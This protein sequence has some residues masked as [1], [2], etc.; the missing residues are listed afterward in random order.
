MKKPCGGA[1]VMKETNRDGRYSPKRIQNGYV[2]AFGLCYVIGFSQC[3]YAQDYLITPNSLP[4]LVKAAMA[5]S[6]C[7][8]LCPADIC[9]L[10]RA[11]S[12]G[13]TG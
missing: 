8:L 10:M 2:A 7:S 13:T 12:L 11:C 9:T 4:I 6:K 1:Y 5:L 3:K